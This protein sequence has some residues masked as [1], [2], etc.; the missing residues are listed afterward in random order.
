[1]FLHIKNTGK[2]S[3]AQIE[4]KGVTV[5]AGVNNTGKSTI[6]KILFCLFNSFYNI[7]QQITI[8]RKK[9]ISN[10]VENQYYLVAKRMTR[11]LDAD[12]FADYIIKMRGKLS[13]FG[14]A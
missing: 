5:I 14:N 13:N 10:I 3:S 9:I 11:R 8:E 2:L 7:D 6:G 12:Y 1:M 4:I